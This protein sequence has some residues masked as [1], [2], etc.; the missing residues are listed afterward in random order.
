MKETIHI[1]HTNDLHSHFERWPR[2]R[3]FLMKRKALH[4][5]QGEA[6]YLFDI[7]DHIDRSHPYTDATRG[8]GNVIMLNEIGYDA[9][10][11][12]NNE[13]ITLSPEELTDL[14]GEAE[15]PVVLDNLFMED[16][17][18][19]GWMVPDAYLTTRSG[20]RIGLIA[21]TADFSTSYERMGW[22][23]T[24]PR[25]ALEAAAPR[26]SRQSDILVCLSHMGSSEDDRLADHTEG[27]IDVILGGHTHHLYPDGREVGGTLIAAA[28]KWGQYIG[29]VTLTFDHAEGRVVQARAEVHDTETLPKPDDD[30]GYDRQLREKAADLLSATVFLNPTELKGGWDGPTPLSDLFAD[31]LLFHTG[32]DCAMFNSGILLG[33]LPEGPISG[34][35][36]HRLLP[37]PIN[38]CVITLS[39]AELEE[40]YDL[41][42]NPE[43]PDIRLKGLG[44]RG[45]KMGAMIH[46]GIGRG[47]DG[48]LYISGS[49]ADSDR[50]YMLA[51][52]DL[53]TYGFFFPAFKQ[54]RKEYFMPELIRDV[55]AGYAIRKF[56]TPSS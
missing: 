11:I 35:D 1:Y 32:A 53:F 26:V 22:K 51:T 34:M 41:S 17:N 46:Q 29:E 5:E 54:A 56:G 33:G 48:K 8:K 14:Y 6:C 28:G 20:I 12:G 18:R 55:L 37:H 42:L 27:R 47:K 24:G 9:V 3:D 49:P 23:V 30:T 38:P 50:M 2:I 44:F 36:L 45:E 13:G 21:A 7:G 19:P 31:A 16:G 52:L 39:G 4:K 40:A 10:T 43:W 15:F 25:S